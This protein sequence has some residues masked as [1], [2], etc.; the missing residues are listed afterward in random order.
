MRNNG[1]ITV[2]FPT[3]GDTLRYVDVGKSVSVQWTG[4]DKEYI[5]EYRVGKDDYHLTGRIS[6]EGNTAHYGPFT[7][8]MWNLLA[9]YNPW[10][11][12]VKSS[13]RVSDWVTFTILPSVSAMPLK[14]KNQLNVAWAF[15]WNE[16]V[17]L[18]GGIFTGLLGMVPLVE[19]IELVNLISIV[20]IFAIL[21]GLVKANLKR[22]GSQRV[23]RWGVT[24]LY[25]T[26]IYSTLSVMPQVWKTLWDFTQGRI[27]YV[28]WVLISVASM[29]LLVYLVVH[30]RIVLSLLSVF[31]LGSANVFLLMELGGS[32]AERIHLTEYGF[33]GF[34]V[35]WALRMDLSGKW[36]YFWGW[37]IASGI[38]LLDEGIQWLLPNRVFEWKD[39]GLNVV[40]SGLGILW[41]VVFQKGRGKE[42]RDLD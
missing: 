4:E 10:K 11:F 29:T 8:D 42:K 2:L 39:V 13:E 7:E 34:L 16:S 23:W 36:F 27:D 12:R 21:V 24:L 32:P 15:W 19:G 30:G 18:F 17:L 9:L 37:M 28:G 3:D 5:V 22:L 40:S 33:L 31:P 35:L 25:T 41:F 14:W 38:G 6:V 20:F 1:P 26:L